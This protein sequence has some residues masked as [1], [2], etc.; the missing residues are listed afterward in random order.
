MAEKSIADK[1]L[2]FVSKFSLVKPDKP[3]SEMAPWKTE[4]LTDEQKIAK[5]AKEQTLKRD[6]AEGIF[7]KALR[8]AGKSSPY[9]RPSGPG[10]DDPDQF[11][12]KRAGYKY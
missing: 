1:I 3:L 5:E 11:F 12:P 10:R 7:S 4:P 9:T 2:D 8:W 6:N